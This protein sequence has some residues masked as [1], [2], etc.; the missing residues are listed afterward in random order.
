MLPAYQ[1]D[2]VAPPEE[3]TVADRVQE[4]LLQ[5]RVTGM[6]DDWLKTLRAQGSVRTVKPGEAMP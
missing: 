6:L 4:I 2:K 5:Q 3:A 1:K